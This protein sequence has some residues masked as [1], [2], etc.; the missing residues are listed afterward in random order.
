MTLLG[1]RTQTLIPEES[2][3]LVTYVLF[4]DQFSSLSVYHTIRIGKGIPV[5]TQVDHLDSK[6][7]FTVSFVVRNSNLL[8]DKEVQLPLPRWQFLFL[9][10]D[11]WM[12]GLHNAQAV[13]IA[14]S[15]LR[16]F[17]SPVEVFLFLMTQIF[18]SAE[19]RVSGI[20]GRSWGLI[21]NKVWYF[22]HCPPST[23]SHIHLFSLF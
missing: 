4:S 13:A 12:Q 11:P 1:G 20:P 9:P 3:P 6:Y 15:L 21:I 17:L 16:L 22:S 23:I 8:S 14:Y 7:T 18:N 19:L 10:G 2:E 5:G